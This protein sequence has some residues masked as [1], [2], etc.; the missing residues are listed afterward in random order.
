MLH[1][2]ARWCFGA[3][4]VA[5]PLVAFPWTTNPLDVNKQAIFFAISAVMIVAWLGDAVAKKQLSIKAN[6]LWILLGV[7]LV[8]VAISAGL[9]AEH[10]TS[11]FGQAS[12][13]YTSAVTIA[14][15]AAVAFIGSHIV[16]AK[17]ERRIIT[18]AV[19]TSSIVG[20]FAMMSWT[21]LA[22]GGIPTNLIGTPN[23][24]IVY[25]L[26]MSVLGC[27][28]MIVGSEEKGVEKTVRMVGTIVTTATTLIALFA[29][30]Y[31]MLWAVALA[32]SIALFVLAGVRSEVMTRPVRFI[33][34]MILCVASLFFLIL[35]ST[36]TSPFPAEV[37]PSTSA[38]WNVGVATLKNGA[39]LFGTGPGTFAMIFAKEHSSDLNTSTFWDTRFDRGS[40]AILTMMPTLGLVATIAFLLFVLGIIV[41]TIRRYLRVRNI[42]ALPAIASW[43]MVSIALFV[44]PQNFVLT[45]VWWMMTALV[46]RHAVTHT[47]TFAFDKSPRVGFGVAFVTVLCSVFV[48]T[49]GFATVARYRAEVAFARA[50]VLDKQ[51]GAIDEVIAELDHAAT[52]NRWSDVYYR[53][54][55]SAL[56]EK[57]AIVVKDPKAD[58]SLVKSLIGAAVNAGV[59]ATELGPT[60]VTNWEL[61]GDIYRSVSPVVADAAEF[62]VASYQKAIELAPKNPK[63]LVDEARGYLAKSDVLAPIVKGSDAAKAAEAKA[64]QDDALSKANDALMAA[65]SLK[66]NYALARYYL[67]SV[68]EHQGKLADAVASMELVRQSAPKDVG[69]GLQL[70]VLYLRQGKSD[71]AKNELERIIAIAPNF[72]NAHW[73]LASILEEEKDIDGAIMELNIILALDPAND[74]VQK[75]LEALKA[76]KVKPV[77]PD[78]LPDTSTPVLPDAGSPTTP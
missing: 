30:D 48:L 42:D 61:R 46:I 44:V 55:G 75:K 38:T 76:G 59:Q 71:V 74:M 6:A 2:L 50:I 29:V 25:L 72:A 28:A 35:P 22:I 23:A 57:V 53:N 1:R 37:A 65:I 78:P 18:I 5:I 36:I 62:S 45:L 56:L 49:V 9:S 54:L 51:G 68:Q 16:D 3:L 39:W 60:N 17:L 69:V 40:S 63:Y 24:L 43:L 47:K 7:F 11:I 4:I 52:V 26:A 13:E 73:Y 14:F 34:P 66:S 20:L 64:A 77:I 27:G 70:A 33:M 67:A 58:P 21:G 32:G 8:A 15:M 10:Y 41:L 12:Q 19:T 31:S